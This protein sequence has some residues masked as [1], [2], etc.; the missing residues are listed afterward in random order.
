MY[1]S[2]KLFQKYYTHVHASKSWEPRYFHEVFII[3]NSSFICL[4]DF[5][6]Q[7]G[8]KI[9]ITFYKYNKTPINRLF[10]FIISTKC[11]LIRVI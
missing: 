7:N 5:S 3:L 11:L 4:F 10:Y 6:E 9:E 8:T 2:L 1:E